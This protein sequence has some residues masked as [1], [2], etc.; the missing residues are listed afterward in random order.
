MLNITVTG[1]TVNDG[2]QILNYLTAPNVIIWSAVMASTAVP[3]VY[4]SVELYCKNEQDEI[5][6]YNEGGSLNYL[7][8]T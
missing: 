8:K 1:V 6:P 2:N 3:Y 5:V 7:V 4:G